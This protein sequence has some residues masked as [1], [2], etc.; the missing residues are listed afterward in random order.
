[1]EVY[2]GNKRILQ[3]N[4]K[5]HSV[6]PVTTTT[7]QDP[8]NNLRAK[9]KRDQMLETEVIGTLFAG[10]SS[11]ALLNFVVSMLL[12]FCLYKSRGT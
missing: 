4:S 3:K 1:M 9:A 6:N 5:L 10:L 12:N 8:K 7:R 2:Y 11:L